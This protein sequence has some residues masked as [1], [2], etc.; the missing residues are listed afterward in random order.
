MK[1][2]TK[3]LQS[4]NL[5]I[6]IMLSCSTF[7]LMPSRFVVAMNLR[8]KVHRQIGDIFIYTP[9]L[10]RLWKNS[11][12]FVKDTILLQRQSTLAYRQL[13]TL[14]RTKTLLHNLR[15]VK[16]D[17]PPLPG[18]ASDHPL[19]QQNPLTSGRNP[20]ESFRAEDPQ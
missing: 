14:L 7:Y 11:L 12:S 10:V 13:E 4:K 16:G 20:S 6:C 2:K 18:G 5:C 19:L 3:K 15:I 1:K 9:A 17:D 8:R